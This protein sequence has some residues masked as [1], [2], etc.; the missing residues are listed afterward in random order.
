M[1]NQSFLTAEQLLNMQQQT[2]FWGEDM[3]LHLAPGQ[4]NKPFALSFDADAEEL[5]FPAIYYGHERRFQI[6]V[7]P[8]MM[9][10]SEIRRR[11]RRGVTPNHIL[12]MAAKIMRLRIIE[13]FQVM[14]RNNDTE[15]KHITR[16]HLCDP[17]FLKESMEKK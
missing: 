15:V 14:F 6:K 7:T 5:S 4:N 2:M 8:Y 13:A 10:T 3:V 17:Q 9:A 16:E 1:K 12:Y 11:D